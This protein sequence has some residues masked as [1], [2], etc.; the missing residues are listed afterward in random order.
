MEQAEI[1]HKLT[2]QHPTCP[3]C[4]R[5]FQSLPD[6]LKLGSFAVN[7]Q[8]DSLPD[9]IKISLLLATTL[10]T[11]DDGFKPRYPTYLE[12]FQTKHSQNIDLSKIDALK[13]TGCH[14]PATFK[15]AIKTVSE[16]YPCGEHR[17]LFTSRASLIFHHITIQH[18]H[19]SLPAKNWYLQ[20]SSLTK[21][22]FTSWS[23]LFNS[24]LW[25]SKTSYP[26]VLRP[27]T[28]KI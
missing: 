18:R 27:A 13:S 15:E 14:V 23:S 4:F 25:I 12:P 11:T 7:H 2:E 20:V 9:H 21:C 16:I 28:K 22:K 17:L 19:K 10:T 8:L 3:E 1:I 26:A 6:H 5:K 24:I